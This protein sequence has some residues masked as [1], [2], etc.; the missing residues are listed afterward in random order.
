MINIKISLFACFSIL[1]LASCTNHKSEK[2]DQSSRIDQMGI[3]VE[4]ASDREY[5]YTDKQS[6]YYYGK[7]HTDNFSEWFAG[8]NIAKQRILSDYTLY[9][10][11]IAQLRKSAEITEV[12]PDRLMRKFGAFTEN[13]YMVDNRKILFISLSQIKTDSVGIAINKGL[14][15]D[16]LFQNNTL[17][18]KPREANGVLALTSYNPVSCTYSDSRLMEPASGE[19]FLLAYAESI[20][21]ADSLVREFRNS[22]NIF[23]QARKERMNHQITEYTP[24]ESNNDTLDQALS[25]IVL[26]TDQLVTDQQGKG[27]YAGLPWFNEYWGRDMFISMP[28]ATLVTGQFET[29]KEILRDFSKFQDMDSTSLT[30]GRIPNRANLDNILYNT[31]DG[32]PRFVIQIEDYLKYSGDVSF[33]QEIYPSVVTSINASIKNYT[34]TLGFLTHADADTW[35]DVKRDGI[36]GSP[37]G[38]R[39]NDIQALWYGQLM[40][41]VEFAKLMNDHLH[42]IEWTN[43][44]YKLKQNFESAFSTNIPDNIA[45]HLNVDGDPDDQFR[46]NQLYVYDLIT[47]DEKK[48]KI[49]RRVWE[50]LVYPW[51]VASLSQNDPDF[52]PYHEN[53]HYYHKDDAYHNGTVWLWN[54]GMAM[55]RMIEMNQQDI[56]YE[57]FKNMNDQ[58]MYQGAI[59][60]LA[61]NADALPRAGET[62]AKRSGTFLQAWSNA[63]QLRVW[64]Q[65]F[66]GIRPDMIHGKILLQPKIPTELTELDF[67]ERIGKG[68]LQGNFVRKGSKSEYEYKL[69]GESASVYFHLIPFP[70]VVFRMDSGYCLKIKQIGTVMETQLLDTKG[71]DIEVKQYEAD[72]NQI[73]RKA[74]QDQFFEGTQFAK[75]YLNPDLKALK[76]YHKEA[77]TY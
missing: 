77:L 40:A 28:G 29:S 14:V 24:L 12:Y 23:L 63:E 32:T 19:G 71:V 11:T 18:M 8:W 50:G 39:A 20:T 15:N 70:P 35:M 2:R 68:M 47:D 46:P 30:Y 26:T 76:I 34:D 67:K 55:Q 51:G 27:I 72:K 25:W 1:V 74:A 37:R 5:S 17:Y 16:S 61:E 48:Q 65:Y 38:N 9:A 49:T 44:A 69:I 52:H 31:T 41:G 64:Y 66:L 53:W 73:E 45:D 3:V 54:N 75:P 22:S 42:V 33:L 57:L 13:F 7:T 10:D 60:S 36:P 56:A 21:M 62:R 58:A 6:A 59:G 4:P 43:A